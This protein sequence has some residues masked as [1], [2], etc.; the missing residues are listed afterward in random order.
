MLYSF[1]DFTLDTDRREL[2]RGAEAISVAPQ[3]FDL[4]IYLVRNR[5][6][7]V[8]K[9]DLVRAVWG[10]RIVSDA[11]VT[12]RINAVRRSVGDSGEKQLLIKT[13][14]RK[15]FRFVGTVQ[16]ER[17][18]S[19]A[20]QTGSATLVG[21]AAETPPSAPRLSIVVLPFANLSGDP[22]QDYFVDGVT[23]S[24]TT[25]LSRISGAFVIG[26]HTAFTY[27]NKAVDLRMIGCELNVRYVLE[28]S[29]QR[30][31]NQL[32]V[33]VQLVDA[34]TGHHLWAERFDK[35]VADLFDM[36]D[37]IVSRLAQALE[38]QLLAAEAQRSETTPSPDAMD[39][40]FLGRAS[41]NKGH[42]AENLSRAR[43]FFQRALSLDSGNIPT[44][45]S[46]AL[47]DLTTVGGFLADD[48]SGHLAAAEANL[49][50]A[51][52]LS[53]RDASALALLGVAKILSNRAAEGIL[54]CEQALAL[55]RNLAYAH[56]CIGVG[57]N[58][59][60][61]A[62][63]TEGHIQQ[64]L[65][66]SPRDI[67][68]FWWMMFAGNA[69]SFLGAYAEAVVW[70][71]R[72]IDTNRNM[73]FAHFNLAAALAQLGRSEEAR[74]AAKMGLTLDPSFTLRR[75]RAN[76]PSDH[77]TFLAGRE[78]IYQGM[79]MAGVPEG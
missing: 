71:R 13:L 59:I 34:E 68:A 7:V 12:T 54:E 63:E 53:P 45:V 72:S 27:K 26:R 56:A 35:P 17:R 39:L 79:R 66:L 16:E 78:G 8:S 62:A 2:R 76:A 73:P 25:D 14:Q 6:R 3:V 58:Y 51:L 40:Y 20:E 67:G 9:D 43:S 64:A 28:G 36:Q 42:T 4:L 60:G 44:L 47:V 77:P 46:M 37:E 69:K 24:L 38:A 22:S 49:V 1:S 21:A 75:F 50:I 18:G 70:L 33:N 29:V 52:S 74:V 32:R 57:K 11:A 23:E 5:E 19:P 48:R 15:G 41:F 30:S 61:R 10:G 65:R 55:D 31:D